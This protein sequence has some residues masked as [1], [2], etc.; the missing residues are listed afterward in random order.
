MANKQLPAGIDPSKWRAASWSVAECLRYSRSAASTEH[1]LTRTQQPP[2]EA[3]QLLQELS[4]SVTF[5]LALRK[6]LTVAESIFL[7]KVLRDHSD[8]PRVKRTDDEVLRREYLRLASECRYYHPKWLHLDMLERRAA[9]DRAAQD[10][11]RDASEDAAQ[12]A[13][14][15]VDAPDGSDVPPWRRWQ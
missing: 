3:R 5:W 6:H 8:W 15:C 13:Q 2:E 14:P 11:Q 12:E 1:C 4:E 10:K 7:L 9:Q